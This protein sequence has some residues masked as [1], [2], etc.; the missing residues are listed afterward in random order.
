LD[1]DFTQGAGAWT[2]KAIVEVPVE[3]MFKKWREQHPEPVKL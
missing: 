1:A 2:V 3:E